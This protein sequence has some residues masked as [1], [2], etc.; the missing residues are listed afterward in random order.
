MDGHLSEHNI[1]RYGKWY[2]HRHNLTYTYTGWIRWTGVFMQPYQLWKIGTS[3]VAF[4]SNSL[5]WPTPW[6]SAVVLHCMCFGKYKTKKI[7]SYRLWHVMKCIKENTSMQKSVLHPPAHLYAG[8]LA[9]L[10]HFDIYIRFLTFKNG[11]EKKGYMAIL[12]L[13]IFTVTCVIRGEWSQHSHPTVFD[14]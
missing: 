4:N 13:L 3:S 5:Q 2:W 11:E 8:Q 10:I 12:A 1:Q 7:S 14:I 6:L 9:S